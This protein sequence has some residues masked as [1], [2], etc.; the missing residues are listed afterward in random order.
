MN[1]TLRH[2]L[3]SLPKARSLD[4]GLHLVEISDCCVKHRVNKILLQ[5]LKLL[6]GCSLS[7]SKSCLL[8]K[9][10]VQLCVGLHKSI[11]LGSVFF[12]LFCY[13]KFVS[14]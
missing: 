10:E 8:I 2:L 4:L 12:E 13:K 5:A 1:G 14:A 9:T 3:D 7:I 6:I 11:T